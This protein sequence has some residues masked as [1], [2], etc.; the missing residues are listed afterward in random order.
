[1]SVD[2]HLNITFGTGA[3][4]NFFLETNGVAPEVSMDNFEVTGDLSGEGQLGFLGVFIDN[5][6]VSATGV[7]ISLYL[8]APTG[9]R[10]SYGSRTTSSTRRRSSPTAP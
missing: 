1:M 8:I 4:G 7:S 2:V 10:L 5:A 3:D 6:T 9:N